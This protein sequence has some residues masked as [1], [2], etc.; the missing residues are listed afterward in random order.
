MLINNS[1]KYYF[2]VSLERMAGDAINFM[3]ILLIIFLAFS[4]GLTE[5]FAPYGPTHHCI[6]QDYPAKEH[7]NTVSLL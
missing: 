5:L 6:C 3:V 2:Q 7:C 1:F 4:S